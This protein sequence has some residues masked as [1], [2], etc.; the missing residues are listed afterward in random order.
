MVIASL[1]GIALWIAVGIVVSNGSKSRLHVMSP[2]PE[3][4]FVLHNAGI[5]IFLGYF[6]VS[7]IDACVAPSLSKH[8]VTAS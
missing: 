7:V 3:N 8:T 2:F 5:C 4:M 6:K 1:L